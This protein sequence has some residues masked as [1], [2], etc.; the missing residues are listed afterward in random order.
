MR[1]THN[2]VPAHCTWPPPH[3]PHP[4]RPGP[5]RSQA[6]A[7]LG[8]CFAS[9]FNT[10]RGGF[11]REALMGSYPRLAAQ[12]EELAQRLV[13]DSSVKDADPALAEDQVGRAALRRAALR[14]SCCVA[15]RRGPQGSSRG[16]A[17]AWS[18]ARPR[19]SC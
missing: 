11:V 10:A 14:R 12:L 15:C 5:A 4:S 2:H 18:T 8:V 1:L 3:P 6:C 19:G 17:A 13:R 9:A 7:A 16:P